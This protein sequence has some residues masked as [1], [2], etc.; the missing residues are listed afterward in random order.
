MCHAHR[1]AVL[2]VALTLIVACDTPPTDTDQPGEASP[3]PEP[4]ASAIVT[5]T[6]LDPVTGGVHTPAQLRAYFDRW[7]DNY[8]LE[9]TEDVVLFVVDP[10]SAFDGKSPAWLAHIPSMSSLHLF[11]FRS[12]PP[13]YR[14]PEG[15]AA[16]EAILANER[17]MADILALIPEASKG[18]RPMLPPSD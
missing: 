12:E 6:P 10:M 18:D 14:T 5:P 13:E 4:I 11:S 17:T 7:S 15:Q 8:K 3:T 2:S 1:L 16:I 9:L